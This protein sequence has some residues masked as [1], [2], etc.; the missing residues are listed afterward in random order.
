MCRWVGW[1]YLL[2]GTVNQLVL[3]G[4]FIAGTYSFVLPQSLGMLVEFLKVN[5]RKFR[6]RQ[7]LELIKDTVIRT[8]RPEFPM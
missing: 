5:T 3:V 2:L 4:A 1:G 6:E 8:P 7:E